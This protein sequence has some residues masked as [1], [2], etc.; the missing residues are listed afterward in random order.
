MLD[1]LVRV[2]RRVDWN[3]LRQ[4]LGPLELWGTPPN[5]GQPWPR[6]LADP[7][8]SL[9]ARQNQASQGQGPPKKG[10]QI[11]SAF[12]ACVYGTGAIT[13]EQGASTPQDPPSPAPFSSR[14]EKSCCWLRPAKCTGETGCPAPPADSPGGS[15][16][17][18]RFPFNNFTY[19]LTL[20]SKFFSSFP[21]GT[22]SL[23]VSRH[24]LALDEVYHPFWAAVP[25]NPT[26]CG[27][28]ILRS[29][30]G[31]GHDTGLSPSLTS[32]SK[33]LGPARLAATEHATSNYNSGGHLKP[34]D[35]KFELFPLHSPLL[36]ESW[37][38]S[39]PPLT[40]ML[41]FSG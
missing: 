38:V 26:L 20:F 33:E 10:H 14:L 4:H 27:H 37:L 17:F 19:F 32:C 39:F 29:G 16:A 35:F 40:D 21:H 34:P 3:H 24:Y 30:S 8:G 12:P 7:R 28:V 25:S 13:V 15:L 22:C 23:S 11:S 18:K 36:G 41:K 1:S 2:S 6:R 5:T 9:P 31:A